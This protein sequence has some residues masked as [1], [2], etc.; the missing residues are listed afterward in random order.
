MTEKRKKGMLYYSGLLSRVF[1]PVEYTHTSSGYA[2]QIIILLLT[3]S[4][5]SLLSRFFC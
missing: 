2:H 4:L 1:L 5:E 3:G